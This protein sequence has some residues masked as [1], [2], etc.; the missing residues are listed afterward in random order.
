[1]AH[2]IG[3]VDIPRDNRRMHKTP[4]ARLGGL[5]IFYGFIVS[6]LCFSDIDYSIRG[7]LIGSVIIVGLGILDDIFQLKPIPKLITQIFAAAV[8]VFHGVQ[9]NYLTNPK[10]FQR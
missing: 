1:L 3:A 2:R 6:I 7:V 10:Y 4:T 8:A 5:A 9:I